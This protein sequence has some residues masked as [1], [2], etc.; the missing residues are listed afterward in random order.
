[1]KIL[2]TGAKGQLGS[3]VIIELEKRGHEVVATDV[4]TLDITDGEAVLAFFHA[5]KPQA[6]IHCAAYT[7]VDKAETE[8]RLCRSVNALG[9]KYLAEE[10]AVFGAKFMYISTEY[11]FDGEKEEPYE[12]N[13]RKAP[14]SVYGATKSEGEEF[15]KAASDK[16]FIVRISWAFGPNGKNFVKTMLRLAETKT[17]LN[18]VCD[19]EGSPTYTPDLA[20]LLADMIGTEKYGVYHATNEGTCSWYEFAC[21]IFRLAGKTVTVHPVTTE[22]YLKLVPQQARRP[23]NSKMDKRKLDKNGFSR[24]PAWEDAL[25][26]FLALE[27]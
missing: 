10:A 3:D 13:D 1:M 19:Q 12:P 9:T 2:V 5:E 25:A 20:R 17:E 7:A 14:R 24:L 23:K 11:V 27:N 22:E 18:V 6:V 4:D 21:E 8:S 26:R 15:V 16:Y